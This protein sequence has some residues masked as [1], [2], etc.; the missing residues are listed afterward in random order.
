MTT[1]L[2]DDRR[3]S[4]V[5]QPFQGACNRELERERS[6]YRFVNGHITAITEPVEIQSVE[7]A[8]E[9]SGTL[10]AV[11]Q[12]I[13][14]A[15]QFLTDRKNPEYRNSIKESISAVES[16]CALVTGQ[17]KSDLN[18][19]L[20]ILEQKYGLHGAL[21]SAFN[22][23]YG[24]T[25]DDDG[26]RHALLKGDNLTFDDAKFMLVTCSA[27]VNYLKALTAKGE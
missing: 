16:M 25:S 8:T 7:D 10:R 1:A 4:E 2:F 11:S 15:L 22:S 21:K 13:E 12:H 18:A 9:F 19:A 24:Y 6:A 27:F 5:N 20:K 3:I 23:L 26:I 14:T 17:E